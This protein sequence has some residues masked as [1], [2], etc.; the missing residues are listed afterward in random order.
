MAVRYAG[1]AADA[2]V[3]DDVP[4]A[5]A[6]SPAARS[7]LEAIRDEWLQ[8]LVDQL[9]EAERTIGR[10]EAERDQ[11]VQERDD[12]WEQVDQLLR[13]ASDEETGLQDAK[14]RPQTSDRGEMAS[15]SMTP[16][17]DRLAL[18]W[19]AWWRRMRGGG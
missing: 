17:S 9:R 4:P 15:E 10:L 18:R 5:V 1:Q 14:N 8:P 7:Q 6:V 2:V 13:S 3:G 11:A 19:R 16:A 12:L